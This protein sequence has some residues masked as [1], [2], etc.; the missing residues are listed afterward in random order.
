MHD[1][2]KTCSMFAEELSSVVN[3]DADIKDKKKKGQ[4]FTSASVAKT[5]AKMVKFDKKVV[6]VLDPGSGIGILTAAIVDR[7][8]EENL[9]VHLEIDAYENDKKVVKYLEE[10]FKY[11]KKRMKENGKNFNYRILETDFILSNKGILEGESDEIKKNKEKF[12]DL[13]ISNPPYFKVNKNHPYSKA[14]YNYIHGQPNVYFMFIIV[15][16]K[17]LKKS[18]QLVFISPRSYCSGAYFALFRE[19]FL[20]EIKPYQFHLFE[21]RREVLYGE[22]IQQ[23][24]LITNAFKHDEN[25]PYIKINKTSKDKADKESNIKIPSESVL[26]GKEKQYLISLPTNKTEYAVLKIFEQW[27]NR[28][29]K[30]DIKISTGQVVKF[31]NKEYLQPYSFVDSYPLFHTRHIKNGQIIFPIQK[32]EQGLRKSSTKESL[33][34]AS[35]NYILLKRISSKEQKKRIECAPYL[36]RRYDFQNICLEDHLNYIYKKKGNL[37]EEEVIGLTAFLN[38][39]LV[40]IYFRINNGNTQVNAYDIQNMPIPEYKFIVKLGEKLISKIITND[41][42]DSYLLSQF[43]L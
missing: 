39:Y 24:L 35:N 38:S 42:I 17:L 37:Q 33:I 18:G 31:R 4:F 26:N 12:Y 10:T 15:G 7:V 30:N 11:C 16:I 19:F 27:T 3:R 2:N 20:T 28:L 8:I 40:D 32:E 29:D 13:V 36:G 25:F 5:M 34:L 14:L 6:K 43:D 22:K 21:S 1:K 41:N 23:E 9:N